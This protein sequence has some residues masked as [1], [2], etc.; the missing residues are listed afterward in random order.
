MYYYHHVPLSPNYQDFA[1]F[2]AQRQ[3]A[4]DAPPPEVCVC[5]S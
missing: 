5:V 3:L 2:R 4:G 1:G